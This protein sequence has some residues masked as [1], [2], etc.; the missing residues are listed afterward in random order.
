MDMTAKAAAGEDKRDRLTRAAAELTYARGF[1]N[2]TLA[3]IAAAAELP[4][5]GVYYYF[6]TKAAIGEAIVAQRSEEFQ[7]LRANWERAGTPSER[8]KAFVQST[9][10]NRDA[11]VRAGCPVGSLCAELGKEQTP[12]GAHV[13]RPLRELLAWLETQFAALG[14][15]RDKTGL[16]MHLL[17]A[18][19]GVSLLANCFRDPNLV[20]EEGRRLNGWLDT[21]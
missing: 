19:Q 2:V 3:D 15:R 18:L 13:G 4:L 20:V 6:R 16:A 9:V 21:L 17:A 5:G 11:L 10:G 8:L 7:Q 14:H 1:A 12:L